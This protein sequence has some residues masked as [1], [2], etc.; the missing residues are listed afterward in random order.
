MEKPNYFITFPSY[1]LRE[2]SAQECVLCG[3]LTSLSKTEGYAYPSNNML[4]QT[5]SCSIETIQRLLLKLENEGYIV[6]E[7]NLGYGRKIWVT[8]KMIGGNLKTDAP[9][10]LNNEVPPPQKLGTYINTNT[11]NENSNKY[12][13]GS[14]TSDFDIVWNAYLKVGNKM[15][16]FA[17]Y[18]KLTSQEKA[19]IAVHIPTYILRHQETGNVAYIPHLTTYLRQRRWEDELPYGNDKQQQ[20]TNVSWE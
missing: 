11:N 8:S 9:P 2:L 15:T 20:L 14:Y 10:H 13:K 17:V 19:D 5:M 6:R 1:L 18:S 12:K 7:T 4:A 16:A 3:L